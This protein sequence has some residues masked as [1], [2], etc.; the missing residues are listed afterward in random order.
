LCQR[1]APPA[2]FNIFICVGISFYS[3][4]ATMKG[5]C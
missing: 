4:A 3:L 2:T 5:A 1:N